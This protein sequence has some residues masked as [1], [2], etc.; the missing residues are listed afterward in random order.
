MSVQREF[1][2]LREDFCLARDL[3]GRRGVGQGLTSSWSQDCGRELDL[4][5]L[6]SGARA[7]EPRGG[8]PN[9]VVGARKRF[10]NGDRTGCMQRVA[11]E[12]G[13]PDVVLDV[14]VVL[15]FV[16]VPL[17]GRDPGLRVGRAGLAATRTLWSWV[18]RWVGDADRGGRAAHR[19]PRGAG[20][21]CRM[22]AGTG[23][24]PRPPPAR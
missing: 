21:R 16:G 1:N 13:V 9:R 8:A 4:S 23:Q 22:Q 11:K 17:V 2:E 14:L 24:N 10:V 5:K 20:F 18:G 15:W 7:P 19:T 3:S 12:P 6:E